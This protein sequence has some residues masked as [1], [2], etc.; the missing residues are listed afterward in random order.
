MGSK[1][2][3]STLEYSMFVINTCKNVLTSINHR[4][5]VCY[6]CKL[7]LYV[8]IHTIYIYIH[9]CAKIHRKILQ[10]LISNKKSLLLIVYKFLLLIETWNLSHFFFIY[11]IDF[12]SLG[13]SLNHNIHF[14]LELLFAMYIKNVSF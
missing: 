10:I 13:Q 5:S 9:I 12:Y 3:L 14:S 8:Y 7:S 2:L 4:K 1:T 11:T 6:Y